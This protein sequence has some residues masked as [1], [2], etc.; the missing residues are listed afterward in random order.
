MRPN[1]D[2]PLSCAA[3][4]VEVPADRA[5]FLLVAGSRFLFRALLEIRRFPA[6][7]TKV[8]V[9]GAGEEKLR[10]AVAKLGLPLLLAPASED[11]V[12]V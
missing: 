10:V 2:L 3:R 8:L 11:F 5:L 4:T 9:I 7:G 12:R 1:G 6:D